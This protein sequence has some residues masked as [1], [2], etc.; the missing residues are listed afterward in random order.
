M[1]K[2]DLVIY[3]YE[4]QSTCEHKG[5]FN[6]AENFCLGDDDKY[7]SLCDNHEHMYRIEFA[8]FFVD[9][10]EVLDWVTHMRK[11]TWYKE[12]M[13]LKCLNRFYKDAELTEH[14]R[15]LLEYA[16]DAIKEG[17]AAY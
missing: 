8:R 16:I 11:K 12:D 3:D 9:E 7:Q 1:S 2:E 4:G 6:P 14:A 17:R 13:F 15:E 5:C 10:R